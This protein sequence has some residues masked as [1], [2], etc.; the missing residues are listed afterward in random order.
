MTDEM[1]HAVLE[2]AGAK[3]DKD[4]WSTLPEGRLMTLYAAHGGVPLTMAKVEAVKVSQRV[5][6]ARTSK[7]E[8]YVVGLEDLFAAALDRGH[9]AQAGRKAGFLG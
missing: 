3:P 9:E 6:W 8:T 1:L 4:G 7:G 5:A 2:T